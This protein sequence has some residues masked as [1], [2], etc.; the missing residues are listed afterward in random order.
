MPPQEPSNPRHRDLGVPTPDPEPVS[1]PRE[2]DDWLVLI[3]IDQYAHG[4]LL[5]PLN[6]CRSDA[7][8][9]RDLLHAKFGFTPE[10]TI[11][12]FDQG[13]RERDIRRT[14]DRL[15]KMVQPEDRVLI[16][17]SGHGWFNEETKLG[18]WF[19]QDAEH[20]SDGI[21]NSLLR[22]W[23]RAFKARHVLVVADSCFS[24][25]LLT[26]SAYA[27]DTDRKS[28]EIL[29][30]GGLHPVA[31]SGS[32][33]GNHSVFNHYLRESLER[34]GAKGS[35]VTNELF[36]DLY[37]PVRANSRQEPVKGPIN[38][39]FHEGGQFRFVPTAVT[40]PPSHTTTASPPSGTETAGIRARSDAR[41]A[42]AE[43][44]ALDEDPHVTLEERV[45]MW[46][47][48]LNRFALVSIPEVAAAR[49]RREHWTGEVA[50]VN[51]SRDAREELE[52]LRRIDEAAKL[53]AAEMVAVIE[54]FLTKHAGVDFPE[55]PRVRERLGHW[56]HIVAEQVAAERERTAQRLREEEARA[57]ARRAVRQELEALRQSD[58]AA[59]L[60]PIEMV[61][62]IEGFLSKHAAVELPEFPDLRGRLVH[63]KQVAAEQA[64]VERES[65]ARYRAE[66][67]AKA[68]AI[69]VSIANPVGHIQ[70]PTSLGTP[71]SA[72]AP[73]T[74]T[75][76]PSPVVPRIAP[77]DIPDPIHPPAKAFA[78]RKPL[79]RG[80]KVLLG[81]I[82][83]TGL[84][85][86]GVV[87]Y[88]AVRPPSYE[89]IYQVA[90]APP[91]P[92]P[93][94]L[95]TPRPPT[96]STGS[97]APIGS[98]N[99]PGANP[100]DRG[101]ITVNG[102]EF[103]FRWC[104]A[105]TFT[106]GSP[107]SEEGRDEDEVQTRVTLT[108]GFWMSETEVT[109][110]QWKAIMGSTV[111][112]QRDKMDASL[113]LRGEGGN[114]P[115]YHVSWNEIMGEQSSGR[116]VPTADSFLG[117]LNAASGQS[118]TLPTEAQWE[119]ACR[120][121]TATR[122][123]FGDSDS[124]L[125]D[126]AWYT[127]NANSTTHPVGEKEPNEWGLR[128]MHGNVYEW[129][130]DWYA[131]TLPGGSTTDPT[132]PG[133]GTVRVIRG[134]SWYC[135]PTYARSANRNWDTPDDRGGD[136]GFRFVSPQ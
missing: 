71:G 88:D 119:Y 77:A 30:A 2:G 19:A 63:W 31:D 80:A 13:A 32:P 103:A 115:M 10:C 22:D 123:G 112:Q 121:G 72:P 94:R 28:R 67:E 11:E 27:P 75:P 66:Q 14:M 73:V 129:C 107:S 36:V 1:A 16:S 69:A 78:P 118:F 131:N 101:T 128:D 132:G 40:A 39:T 134:G 104:P 70:A 50:R 37:T 7:E 108:K 3:A 126:S 105:D 96:P 117:K 15:Q 64:R 62:A 57:A 130:A 125:G 6:C 113:S 56:K 100:G 58:K 17:F 93:S 18:C 120:A 25:S 33:D 122:F 74:S 111:A 5:T 41:R 114:Y 45:E 55:L 49:E 116:P 43:A 133:T 102:V 12:L 90:S 44:M 92:T 81:A 84:S 47:D 91:S 9:L 85:V 135:R 76:A 86:G 65:E 97:M 124:M 26:R 136:L 61:A 34:L 99:R 68:V 42:F 20:E 82:I 35:F 52:Q 29:G 59:K 8:A 87:T 110:A 60:P 98:I 83:L 89:G 23:C 54:R 24:G 127:E 46:E 106:M 21:P 53:P 48:Y 4:G 95:P 109:Q 38:D 79:G 51:A